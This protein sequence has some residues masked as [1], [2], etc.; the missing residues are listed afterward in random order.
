MQMRTISV[1]LKNKKFKLIENYVLSLLKSQIIHRFSHHITHQLPEKRRQ[2]WKTRPQY[3][4]KVSKELTFNDFRVLHSQ[5]R[6]PRFIIPD[7]ERLGFGDGVGGMSTSI[8]S[9]TEKNRK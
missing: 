7:S 3:R 2:H 9:D 8:D 5:I 6:S 4:K 1:P